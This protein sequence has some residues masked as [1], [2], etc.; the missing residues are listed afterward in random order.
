M[1][2][3][4]E[5]LLVLMQFEADQAEKKAKRMER[6][7]EAL[8]RRFDPLGRATQKYNRDLKNLERALESGII[9]QGRY[10]ANLRNLEEE[11]QRATRASNQFAN[12]G[13]GLTGKLQANRAI[14]QQAGY[15]VG[16]FAVQV[17]GG[18]S[19]LIAFSQQGSQLLGAFGAYGAIAGAAL[20]V[21]TPLVGAFLNSANA[22]EDAADAIGNLDKRLDQYRKTSAELQMELRELR[23]GVDEN[24]LALLDQL[25]INL[26]EVADAEK[27][28]DDAESKRLRGRGSLRQ[29]LSDRK[30][31]LQATRDQLDE[32][33]V[34]RQ[35]RET[36]L[37][38]TR[39]TA[40]A[41]RALGELLTQTVEEIA[42]AEAIA[43]LLK[44]GLSASAIEALELA[45]IDIAAG[46]DEAAIAAAKLADNLNISLQEALKLK[47]LSDDPL[48]AFGGEGQF[49]PDQSLSWEEQGR[50]AAEEAARS[51]RSGGGSSGKPQDIDF[52][53][54]ITQ[55]ERQLKLLGKSSSEITELETKWRLLDEAK[56]K[57]IDV[58][59]AVNARI[60]QTASDVA[61]LTENLERGRIAQQTY[62]Q[63]MQ[64]IAE[65]MSGA[66]VQGEGL[67]GVL[68]SLA[69]QLLQ[70]NLSNLLSHGFSGLFPKSSFLGGLLSFDGGGFTGSGARSGGVDGKGGF[71]AILHPN[72]TVIDHTKA[73]PAGQSATHTTYNIDA[74]GAVEGTAAQI[75]K[76][77][78]RATPGIQQ[79][80]TQKTIRYMSETTN[81]WA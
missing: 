64:D 67:K 44:G 39:E 42:Q 32:F 79:G 40:D 24:E 41:E 47:A 48:G 7:V 15:Q 12:V 26:K 81:G 6:Q 28:L 73:V 27:A 31:E 57:G 2:T 49:I 8:E 23:L 21:T 9:D 38:T 75:Q 1:T 4:T 33:R 76:A 72:E 58:D 77:I 17:Q 51:R 36:L 46:V 18:T 62:E 45:G 19:A 78:E 30:E 55:L 52:H 68:E 10:Q 66:I 14:L 25:E 69:K 74:R 16:D 71:P 80:A 22:A 35:E 53:R 50:I 59:D 34:M 61:K 43:E 11:F 54:E 37:N 13:G 29:A 60:E 20:A 3:E 63:G 65:S 56:R 70:R 5:R